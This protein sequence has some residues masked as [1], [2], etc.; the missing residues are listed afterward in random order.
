MAVAWRASRGGRPIDRINSAGKHPSREVGLAVATQ[1]RDYTLTDCHPGTGRRMECEAVTSPS[2]GGWLLC[3][4]S[5]R[6]I[7]PSRRARSMQPNSKHERTS[8]LVRIHD[9]LQAAI[10]GGVSI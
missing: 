5:Y 1:R 6:S 4:R 7:Y 9:G 3:P 10:A 8:D 2:V